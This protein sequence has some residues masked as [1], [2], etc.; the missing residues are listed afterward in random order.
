M[1]FFSSKMGQFTYFSAQLGEPDWR[2]KNVLD[3]GGNIGNML[4]DPNST[5]DQERYWCID[6]VRDSIERGKASFPLSHWIFYDRYCFFFNPHGVPNLSLPELDHTFFY[7]VAYSVFTNTARTEMLQLVGQ[8]EAKL[9]DEG[10]LAFTFIDPNYCSWPQQYP[11]NNFRWRMEREILLEKEKGHTL[12]IDMERLGK[13][14]KAAEWCVLVNGEDL[15][16]ETEETKTYEPQQQRTCHVF[17][18]VEY[19][20]ALFPHAT[21][22]PPVNNEMQHCCVISKS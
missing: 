1:A 22:L 9:C 10:A 18:T 20:K 19:M 5:I 7:I 2:G 15:Y 14:A 8:L 3:F 13:K 12:D 6:V 16:L 17:Y 4:R 21:I 11:G